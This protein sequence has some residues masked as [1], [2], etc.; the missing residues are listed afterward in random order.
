MK[1]E[2]LPLCAYFKCNFFIACENCRHFATGFL[3]KWR[4]TNKSG[5]S[6]Q[7][8]VTF[9][10]RIGLQISWF[11]FPSRQDQSEAPPRTGYWHVISMEFLR[12][13][14][15]RYFAWKPMLASW[16]ICCFLRLF[17]YESWVRRFIS[18]FTIMKIFRDNF[19]LILGYLVKWSII[20]Y[21][22]V[23][24]PLQNNLHVP[25]QFSNR[26]SL[27]K[28]LVQLSFSLSPDYLQYYL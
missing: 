2:S 25:I 21:G 5:V 9:Q 8:R 16:N 13:F 6:Y 23:S 28:Y 12:S 1:G 4:L 10:V 18:I 22:T 11:K 7:W 20:L 14:L 27:S 24:N 3:A 26:T 17:F 19:I 15:M